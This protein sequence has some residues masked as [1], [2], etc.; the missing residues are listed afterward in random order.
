MGRGGHGLMGPPQREKE[1]K[2][3]RKK[4]KNG[5]PIFY[6][7]HDFSTIVNNIPKLN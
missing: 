2:L 5:K 3:K 4:K 7:H 1:R 6:E